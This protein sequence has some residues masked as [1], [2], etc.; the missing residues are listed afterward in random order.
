ME[1]ISEKP[2]YITSTTF[3]IL[4]N[5]DIQ[6]ESSIDITTELYS[7]TF[8]RDILSHSK[9]GPDP[10]GNQLCIICKQKYKKCN[11]HYGQ[12]S[13]V[14]LY[15]NLF[16]PNILKVLKNVCINC[17][18][19]QDKNATTCQIC[20]T[21]RTKYV[22][23]KYVKIYKSNKVE[24]IAIAKEIQNTKQLQIV[25]REQVYEIL[26]NT[27]PMILEKLGSKVKSGEDLMW[28]SFPILPKMYRKNNK[29]GDK[30]MKS[31][32]ESLYQQMA[33]QISERIININN[34]D[35][36][37]KID[38]ILQ[39]AEMQL[40]DGEKY[41]RSDGSKNSTLIPRLLRKE[42]MIINDLICKRVNNCLRAVI[43]PANEYIS[44]NEIGIPKLY[45][46]ELIVYENVT[47]FNI[48]RLN[49]ML[50][51]KE[52][53]QIKYRKEIL[54]NGE[55]IDR[56]VI[57]IDK[58]HIGDLI[59]RSLI[60]GDEVLANRSPTLTKS[61]ILCFKAK[62]TNSEKALS[63]H[64]ATCT[65]FGADFDG[66]EM[67][68]FVLKHPRTRVE[69]FMKMSSS[70][71]IFSSGFSGVLIA[72]TQDLVASIRILTRDI[73]Y[74]QE[75]YMEYIIS[76][77][78]IT[79]KCKP[80]YIYN[81]KEILKYTNEN[82]SNIKIYSG[83]SIFSLIL[84]EKFNYE[85]YDD[86]ENIRVKIKDGE[87]LEGEIDKFSVMKQQKGLIN[88]IND[89]YGEEEVVVFI[90][91]LHMLA[92]NVLRIYGLTTG[93]HD[94]YFTNEQMKK[95]NEIKNIKYINLYKNVSKYESITPTIDLIISNEI[96]T[97]QNSNDILNDIMKTEFHHFHDIVTC[98]AKGTTG[99]INKLCYSVGQIYIGSDRYIDRSPYIAKYD[100]T[101]RYGLGIIE[102]GYLDCLNIPEIQM[103][104]QNA[105][106]S[107]I[108]KHLSVAKPGYINT[109]V[110]ET[111]RD[112]IFTSDFTV[113]NPLGEILIPHYFNS[114][115]TE[116]ETQYIIKVKLEDLTINTEE[117]SK[118]YNIEE[119]KKYNNYITRIYKFMDKCDKKLNK[120]EVVSKISVY[121]PF[122]FELILLNNI[123]DGKIYKNLKY[124]IDKI[125]EILNGY[126]TSPFKEIDNINKIP[127]AYALYY[128]F[129][130]KRISIS[131]ETYD[132]LF[133]KILEKIIFAQLD[134][135][136]SILLKS[137]TSYLSVV[138]QELLKSIHGS[139]T[140]TAEK[141]LGD[142]L[143]VTKTKTNELIKSYIE[144]SNTSYHRL[145]ISELTDEITCIYGKDKNNRKYKI[146]YSDIDEQDKIGILFTFKFNMINMINNNI[147]LPYIFVNM[148][149]NID[150]II[151]TD[152]MLNKILNYLHV[153]S[154]SINEEP[155][156]SILVNGT[157]S[158]VR[159]FI[160]QFIRLI[161][162]INICETNIKS[163]FVYE[164]E[165]KYK[166][167]II[168]GINYKDALQLPF[169]KS[170]Y[171][172]TSHLYSVY[173]QYG[174]FAYLS[175]SLINLFQIGKDNKV[176]PKHGASISCI[177]CY[178]N[179]L[180][181]LNRLGFDKISTGKWSNIAFESQ[182]KF[183]IKAA[184]NNV[185]DRGLSINSQNIFGHKLKL[186][187]NHSS[188]TYNLDKLKNMSKYKLMVKSE[189]SLYNLLK[190]DSDKNPE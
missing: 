108:I 37:T 147:L 130:P 20:D 14:K 176:N 125:D 90:D 13:N 122:D 93:L 79:R 86:S 45:A 148:I 83:K 41:K 16:V 99:D 72:L 188:I 59:A 89:L 114:F 95:M 73:F 186:G 169:L 84:P 42:G 17:K 88:A 25:P 172:L 32:I 128:Y 82:I 6:R 189:N 35:K 150:E 170:D 49:D 133:E 68:V 127:M 58:L 24:P 2:N 46:Q 163:I 71:N 139:K 171:I 9:F 167:C 115:D 123:K 181:S 43:I 75:Q 19:L 158:N 146:L 80:T 65:G 44:I 173:E 26:S 103:G 165:Y 91:N 67:S 34:Q 168:D 78:K 129:N 157:I 97:I 140:H 117:E 164:R 1:Y 64:L 118:I 174:V 48:H 10:V 182:S 102:S 179:S 12:F 56:S 131:K 57:N 126:N 136:T 152:S 39:V 138:S 161:K 106:N 145:L 8:K 51:N 187:T 85:S 100:N 178:N 175:A 54:E 81:G 184:S 27:S 28:T 11:G 69:C 105:L 135:G 87:L 5:E 155:S 94:F 190:R 4:S 116:K 113:R 177:I 119:Y 132:I 96:N 21:P 156:I 154:S 60:D 92:S 52:Y 63:L 124:I 183:L 77:L 7:A 66:D 74:V 137:G 53:P 36:L 180:I 166:Q 134:S 142:T 30:I 18:S 121:L 29:I 185:T 31:H 159:L 98:G 111:V 141:S 162:E 149:N 107:E 23:Y 109:R 143:S 33:K 62:I 55:E 153:S 22:I 120:Y 110:N 15:R 50:Y 38:N 151:S 144:D 104:N 61:S 3:S 70:E 160:F 112:N 76:N 47:Q 40:A 101:S